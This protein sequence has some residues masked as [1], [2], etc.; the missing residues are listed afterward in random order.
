MTIAY[1]TAYDSRSSAEAKEASIDD[2]S[3]IPM[4]LPGGIRSQVHDIVFTSPTSATLVYDIYLDGLGTYPDRSV[5]PDWWMEHGGHP[6]H[7]LRR[8][9]AGVRALQLTPG[10]LISALGGLRC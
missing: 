1:W 8:C 4:G 5:R 3:G 6:H 2:V 9:R 7:D 10:R